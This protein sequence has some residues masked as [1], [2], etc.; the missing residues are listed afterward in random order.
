MATPRYVLAL[1]AGTTS[2]RAMLFDD[3]GLPRGVAQRE[4]RQCY[5]QPGWVEHDPLEISSAQ[6]EVA[7]EVLEQQR[8]QPAAVR[9][10][11]S[12]T[13]ARRPSSGI[14]PRASRCIGRWSGRIGAPPAG[15]TNSGRPGT[16]RGWPSARGCCSM[17]TSRRPSWPGC[18][19]RCPAPG[20]A[21]RPASWRLGRSTPVPRSARRPASERRHNGRRCSTTSHR[22][23]IPTVRVDTASVCPSAASSESKGR[24]TAQLRAF[25][26]GGA[27]D[28]RPRFGRPR[29]ARAV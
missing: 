11:G 14:G 9:R 24:A 23:G 19:T 29:S 26:G 20:P 2:V 17:P 7:V 28:S 15:V 27:G 22:P 4:I 3:D 13:S 5:P 8:L 18:S 16:R 10:S 6:L 12:R 1:D 25:R 21:P